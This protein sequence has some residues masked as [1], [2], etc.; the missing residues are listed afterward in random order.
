MSR[1]YG[2]A[3]RLYDLGQMIRIEHTVFA[4][5]FAFA[6]ALL[7]G[8]SLGLNRG[9]PP[10]PTLGWIVVA[11]FGARS[12]AMAFNRIVDARLDAANPRTSARHIPAGTVSFRQAALFVIVAAALLVFAAARLNPLC[13]KLSPLALAWTLGYSYT[14]RFTAWSHLVLGI[15]IGAAPLGAWIA[16]TGSFA[17][18]P[19]LLS[20]AVALWIA[21]FDI[22]YA[23]QD[24]EV[25]RRLGLHSIP[26]RLGATRALQVARIMHAAM[27]G[28]LGL[29][30]ITANL[31][32][33]YYSGLIVSAALLAYEHAI[34]HPRDLSRVNTA[35]FTMNGWVSIGLFAFLALDGWFVR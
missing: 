16:V 34:V 23:L 19:I 4:L 22:I 32:F 17:V 26:A 6:G 18:T 1:V 21:G 25:D 24:M 35:F 15:G 33:W 9:W 7:A 11:M 30:G 12:A 5:P 3:R 13:L 10:W 28:L 14:K 31:G 8:R 2:A 27:L 20:A 29:T